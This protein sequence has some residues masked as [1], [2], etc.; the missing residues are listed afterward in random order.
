MELIFASV[1]G[2]FSALLWQLFTE[3]FRRQGGSDARLSWVG[4]RRARRQLSEGRCVSGF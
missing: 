3:V 4:V 2:F 1:G